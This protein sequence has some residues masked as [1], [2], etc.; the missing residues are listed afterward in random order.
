M[1]GRVVGVPVAT[2]WTAPDAPRP[3]DGAAVADVPD[4]MAWT[5]AMD[6]SARRGLHGRTLTQG[7]LGEPVTVVSEHGGWAEVVLPE[8]P[9]SADGRGYP[10]WMRTS[11]LA[12]SP[13]GGETEMVVTATESTATT[14]YG[15][16]RLS[17]G[18]RL[19]VLERHGDRVRVALPG[20]ATA[21]LPTADLRPVGPGGDATE[22]LAS[23]R[24]FLGLPY[25]WGGTSAWGLDC[26]GLVHLV[27]RQCGQ[28]VPRDAF[29][30][31]S[32]ATSVPLAEAAPGDLYFFARP[33]GKVHHVGLATN[34]AGRPLTMLHAPEEDAGRIEQAAL[35]RERSGTLV[36]AGSFLRAEA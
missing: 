11:H 18:T 17:F 23:A 26:S 19:P 28:R 2:L 7:L 5:S 15:A 1:T 22:L 12:A 29:D 36:G 8:Q 21:T 20:A 14:S 33:G 25:L 13:R 27:H 32:G 10:G 24:S 9:S 4:V 31:A 3:Q 34:A 6:E 35:T 16:L 30:Q